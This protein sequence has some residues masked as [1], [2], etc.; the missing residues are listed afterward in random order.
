[1]RR[2]T[3]FIAGL[4]L[5]IAL[6]VG[7]CSA[8][9]PQSA[10]TQVQPTA[11]VANPGQPVYDDPFTY[12]AAIGTID[13]PNEQY[14]GPKMPDSIVEG[15]LKQGIVSS[16][17]PL[18]FQKNAVW[19]CMDHSVW[20]CHFGAN[21]PCLEKA[22][23]SKEATSGMED[24]CKTSPTAESIPAVVTGRATIFEWKCN[25]GKPEI[26]RQVFQVD[27]QGYLANFWYKL[28]SK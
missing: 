18:E 13:T 27:H 10:L 25:A 2:L 20:V 24:F 6:F 22:D 21:L 14:T 9:T 3:K 5:S 17:A 12:C 26:V 23:T 4:F 11:V 16:D 28:S 19:R 8:P 1:M 15:M 7:A